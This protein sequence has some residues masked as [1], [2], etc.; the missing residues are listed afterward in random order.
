MESMNAEQF[1][2]AVS[3]PTPTL[4]DFYAPWCV[5]CRRIAPALEALAAKHAQALRIGQVS[6]DTE[7]LLAQE[8]GIEVIPTLVLYRDGKVLSSITAPESKAA[9]DAFLQPYL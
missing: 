7:P 6:I 8:A 1:R 4:I 9:L 5:H 3:A 2:A